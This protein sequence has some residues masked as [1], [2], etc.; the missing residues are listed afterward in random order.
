MGALYRNPANW[1][2]NF[3]VALK[4]VFLAVSSVVLNISPIVRNRSP[5]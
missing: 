2:L 4:S 3:L 1:V 5:W